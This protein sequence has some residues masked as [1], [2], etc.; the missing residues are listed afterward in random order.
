MSALTIGS[1]LGD[2]LH[3]AVQQHALNIETHLE[4]LLILIVHFCEQKTIGDE[5]RQP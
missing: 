4:I 3:H 2:L 1:T 5:T